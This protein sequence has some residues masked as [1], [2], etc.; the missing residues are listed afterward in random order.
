M[1]HVD[2]TYTAG[3]DRDD[4]EERLRETETGVLS[5]VD[6]DEAY[7]IPL[8]YYYE[9]GDSL[10]FRLGRVEDS[11]KIAAIESTGRACF[12]V[13]DYASPTESWSV[14]A[15]GELRQVPAD[16]PRYDDAEMNRHFPDLRVFDEAID[17][18]ELMLYELWMDE[19]TGRETV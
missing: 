11:E 14:L 8:A 19:V 17:E 2:F 3:M 18:V 12:V 15:R 9:G 7:G 13:Y 6:G 10:L 1:D 4:V 5:L 16:D